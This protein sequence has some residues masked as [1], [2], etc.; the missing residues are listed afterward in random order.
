MRQEGDKVIFEKDHLFSSPS[1]AAIALMG[2]N[3]NGWTE[4]RD[5]NG[6]SLDKLKR[7]PGEA[8]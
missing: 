8:K 4:W 3:A 2:R 7:T 1:M 6:N 5:K